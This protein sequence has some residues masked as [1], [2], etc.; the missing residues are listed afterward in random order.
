MNLAHISTAVGKGLVAGLV[1]TA[2]MT[3]SST[4]EMKLRGRK[5][6]PAPAEAL[7]KLLGVEAL[8]ET[9]KTRLTNLVHWTYGTS[10]GGLRGVLG[11]AGLRGPM[12]GGLFLGLVWGGEM[13]TLPALGVAPPVTQ[14]GAEGIAIDG[15][16]HLVYGVAATVAYEFIDR[17]A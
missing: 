6:S 5:A 8:G 17:S 9:E 3:L 16:H 10:L 11:A 12:A 2:A 4:A 15:L 13:T 1:G 14:W 7:C